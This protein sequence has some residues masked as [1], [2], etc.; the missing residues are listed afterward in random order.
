MV[1]TF[2]QREDHSLTFCPP[3]LK[4]SPQDRLEGARGKRKR[5]VKCSEFSK[6]I[7]SGLTKSKLS[8]P[9]PSKNAG[10]KR[11]RSDTTGQG[12]ITKQSQGQQRSDSADAVLNT[13]NCDPKQHVNDKRL[14]GCQRL[15]EEIETAEMK[16]ST[17]EI[18]SKSKDDVRTVDREKCKEQSHQCQSR[19]TRSQQNMSRIDK[20]CNSEGSKHGEADNHNL[21]QYLAN[22]SCGAMET[23]LLDQSSSYEKSHD[24]NIHNMVYNNESSDDENDVEMTYRNVCLEDEC[25]EENV[26][27]W[28][29]VAVGK[30][31]IS[32]GKEAKLLKDKLLQGDTVTC[33]SLIKDGICKPE[34]GDNGK[35]SSD[36]KLNNGDNTLGIQD[37]LLTVN[38]DMDTATSTVTGEKERSEFRPKKN[39][40]FKRK[41][42]T[43]DEI[44]EVTQLSGTS[45]EH[46]PN[47]IFNSH[48]PDI[49]HTYSSKQNS[50]LDKDRMV[51]KWLKSSSYKAGKVSDDHS[52]LE[53]ESE[54]MMQVTNINKENQR[55]EGD[56]IIKAV[57]QS[58]Q[59][60]VIQEELKPVVNTRRK[61]F[62]TKLD[63]QSNTAMTV[64]QVKGNGKF[65]VR[66]VSPVR[67]EPDLEKKIP[68]DIKSGDK[69]GD[70][71]G[72]DPYEFKPSQRT[73]KTNKGKKKVVRKKNEKKCHKN[74][75]D[76]K[77][78]DST[79]DNKKEEDGTKAHRKEEKQES[80]SRT[81]DEIEGSN[82][83]RRRGK[84]SSTKS[85]DMLQQRTEDVEKIIADLTQAEEYDF[86]TCTQEA[87]DQ[88]TEF[89]DKIPRIGEEKPCDMDTSNLDEVRK[90]CDKS[91][92]KTWVGMEAAQ[93]EIDIKMGTI[94]NP[95]RTM[96]KEKTIATMQ[97]DLEIERR[98][99]DGSEAASSNV[100][101]IADTWERKDPDVENQE[102][103]STKSAADS[104][105][106][107]PDTE[108]LTM[109]HS[110]AD[111]PVLNTQLEDF[112]GSRGSIPL[113]LSCQA[114]MTEEVQSLCDYVVEK[115][116]NKNLDRK[117]RKLCQ[118]KS[119]NNKISCLQSQVEDRADV[120]TDDTE[121]ASFVSDASCIP[122]TE[123]SIMSRRTRKFRSNLRN[124]KSVSFIDKV[125]NIP[126]Q[127][128]PNTLEQMGT[129][130]RRQ[131]SS[132]IETKD[133]SHD[134]L[135]R[136][137]RGRRSPGKETIGHP[138]GLLKRV[139]R[140]QRSPG[141][142]S[143]GQL[144]GVTRGERSS[145]N[146]KREEAFPQMRLLLRGDGS[147]KAATTNQTIDLC[148]DDQ[149]ENL[150]HESNRE[151]LP[152][153]MEEDVT[154]S[155]MA[156]VIP[157]TVDDSSFNDRQKSLRVVQAQLHSTSFQ[158]NV[159]VKKQVVRTFDPEQ[160]MCTETLEDKIE[161]D[162]DAIYPCDEIVD[163]SACTQPPSGDLQI[164]ND[165][166]VNMTTCSATGKD[167]RGKR[168][169]KT[170]NSCKTLQK[171]PSVVVMETQTSG[172]MSSDSVTLETQESVSLLI[173]NDRKRTEEPDNLLL[174]NV[175]RDLA[176][177]PSSPTE[178][179]RIEDVQIM[180]KRN[181]PKRLSPRMTSQYVSSI[182]LTPPSI[183]VDSGLKKR[184]SHPDKKPRSGV[185]AAGSKVTC[186]QDS[187]TS[188]ESIVIPATDGASRDI[189]QVIHISEVENE[190]PNT[191][192]KND[193]KNISID[194]S[195]GNS[196]LSDVISEKGGLKS[197][198]FQMNS[199]SLSKSLQRG[200][201]KDEFK[202]DW[203]KGT[204]S[205]ELQTVLCQDH[206][207]TKGDRK[208]IGQGM[209]QS[210]EDN[211]EKMA[212][213][214]EK[215]SESDTECK[216]IQEADEDQDELTPTLKPI[217]KSHNRKCI[218]RQTCSPEDI[219][220]MDS[221]AIVGIHDSSVVQNQ[222]GLMDME[223]FQSLDSS[224]SQNTEK[225]D[226]S[227]QDDSAHSDMETSLSKSIEDLE[228]C[229]E[230]DNEVRVTEIC[231]M[232]ES[233][234]ESTEEKM[235]SE[236]TNDV[237]TN[238]NQKRNGENGMCNND[239]DPDSDL[240]QSRQTRRT[241]VRCVR[242]LATR[243]RQLECQ[244]G[245][246]HSS[247]IV[248][249]E[250]IS[251]KSEGHSSTHQQNSEKNVKELSENVDLENEENS[252]KLLSVGESI[253]E[254]MNTIRLKEKFKKTFKK[255]SSRNQSVNKKIGFTRPSD[256]EIDLQGETASH[257]SE[258][259]ET[260]GSVK[261]ENDLK[262]DKFVGTAEQ[263]SELRTEQRSE[264]DNVVPD[265]FP[266][267]GKTLKD[268]S[269]SGQSCRS[270][271]IVQP[272][273]LQ[274]NTNSIEIGDPVEMSISKRSPEGKTEFVTDESPSSDMRRRRVVGYRRRRPVIEESSDDMCDASSP[275]PDV[276]ICKGQQTSK[277]KNS[278]R[279][280]VL[281]NEIKNR[282]DEIDEESNKKMCNDNK[283][284]TVIADSDEDGNNGY[285]SSEDSDS[286]RRLNLTSSSAFSSQSEAMTTQNRKALEK[287]LERMK[288]EIA[289]L[290]KQLANTPGNQ[291]LS[292]SRKTSK[293]GEVS[294]DSDSDLVLEVN[295]DDEHDQSE[296][297]QHND[298][299]DLATSSSGFK[300]SQGSRS[301]ENRTVDS[302]ES[303]ELFLSPLPPSPPPTPLQP[304][305]RSSVQLPDHIIQTTEFLS[306]FRK[307]ASDILPNS[308]GSVRS[309]RGT[310]KK[311]IFSKETAETS[312][313]QKEMEHFT[314]LSSQGG[315]TDQLK[316][317]VTSPKFES[318]EL[319][320]GTYTVSA[321]EENI[322]QQGQHRAFVTT[323]LTFLQMREIQKLAQQNKIRFFVKF[324]S[325]VTHV[326]VK[327]VRPGQRVCERTLKFFQ[328][329]AHQCWVLDYQWVADS[330]AAGQLL[331]EDKYEIVGDTITGNCHYGP[332]QSRL[333][334]HP[335][336]NGF[337]FFCL[338]T[339][340]SLTTENL[341]DLIERCGGAVVDHPS[342]FPPDSK[343]N[344]AVTCVDLEDEDDL[345]SKEDMRSF[346][347]LYKKFGLL[348]VSREWILDTLTVY[349]VQP[350]MDYYH[351]LIGF[352][353]S[354]AQLA[355]LKTSL[356]MGAKFCSACCVK[357]KSDY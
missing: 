177:K 61:I 289:E 229:A 151:Q 353:Q 51:K 153:S 57:D 16:S 226:F 354:S 114:V 227:D 205:Q 299:I 139:T 91:V 22:E 58:T 323:G 49:K 46:S 162:V 306:H 317:E 224:Q 304:A 210:R 160:E 137:T 2:H 72:S 163:D 203:H 124:R 171:K 236:L 64:Q 92:T 35:T 122:N 242:G 132:G 285:S 208:S 345:P 82:L 43:E 100:G 296:A 68:S 199:K 315:D 320:G 276:V 288:R 235:K 303:D 357:A 95:K 209:D 241:G 3:L 254:N 213:E 143:Q 24:T 217:E 248:S 237:E 127:V 31:L 36:V 283:E 307:T 128:H 265:S 87:K 195:S 71:Q 126:V 294:E 212:K 70:S 89:E 69:I 34:E 19:I 249:A 219:F 238:G 37:D 184:L 147:Q 60:L 301:K 207:G 186:G 159:E 1:G 39:P 297:D 261:E 48:V 222:E 350:L 148:T 90:K 131:M 98:S 280:V 259:S 109:K 239:S 325:A 281:D 228:E 168:T 272:S 30:D 74:A 17:S 341:Q 125:Q 277:D 274:R 258:G 79:V 232:K 121:C 270:P 264:S 63:Q 136:V 211:Q 93:E 291:S 230:N 40:L 330:K 194:I 271:T 56:S 80:R 338:G 351:L 44:D 183:A 84:T 273:V 53:A 81:E 119:D 302:D 196:N 175:K 155:C 346:N 348:T 75:I 97:K 158:K 244:A 223:D 101:I 6:S 4:N 13:R 26:V 170:R 20:E 110:E 252:S 247:S 221:E 293:K 150:V 349:T 62:K 309:D 282:M 202:V 312:Q 8:E 174:D 76:I 33:G 117:S 10:S 5:L 267:S 233:K 41:Q 182:S 356:I 321:L 65:V 180:P 104:I 27:E 7:G 144:E 292:N 55:V 66:K 167:R 77:I 54:R 279:Q 112:S 102:V 193:L 225:K 215:P 134:H 234:S 251:L 206:Q 111:E 269:S 50:K 187:V 204:P 103:L 156:D 9:A 286:S 83:C 319:A 108:T 52:M 284:T 332:R 107:I 173:A 313:T 133:N 141:K 340:D 157:E 28:G 135:E 308:Q 42:K 181:K 138:P 344:L 23:E 188:S 29:P 245:S 169:R 201:N 86:I 253:S 123:D 278:V 216:V 343:L 328:G 326:I 116:I 118:D 300:L 220:M 218:S 333:S 250:R 120:N 275:L 146:D 287:D 154:D 352:Q 260:E 329:V 257:I 176:D 88:I 12:D 191:E 11:R 231:G 165:L 145:Q 78:G 322:S 327:T 316:K 256:N 18:S 311:T 178:N 96:K 161:T 140:G 152:E 314:R 197:R 47:G 200:G 85:V 318:S 25:E 38:S 149:G 105:E 32:L 172:N 240:S 198:K 115:K 298:V 337:H 342:A 339:S 45:L 246:C 21:L 335:L 190:V 99:C 142:E 266:C 166:N 262:G 310:K 334:T 189:T 14:K 94:D 164:G 192:E 268:L 295:R 73:P 324:N 355:V 347:K 214:K 263:R 331:P 59:D 179:E 106:I 67:I 113:V 243:K 290:E 255:R 130:T 305:K 15:L 129:D 336:L 185:T